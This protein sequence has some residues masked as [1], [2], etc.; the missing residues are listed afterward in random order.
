M[1]VQVD[2]PFTVVG[3]I[4]GQYADLLR[5]FEMSGFPPD[6]KYLFLGDY[7][8]RGPQGLE[9]ILLLLCYKIRYPE[10]IYLLRGNH[11]CERICDRRVFIC[12]I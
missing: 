8:D 9:T 6:T 11:E 5:I 1:L 7:V 4:H 3:D 2:A 10:N 12:K